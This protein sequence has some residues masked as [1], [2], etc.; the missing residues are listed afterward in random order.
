MAYGTLC[1]LEN[2]YPIEIKV[3]LA[4]LNNGQNSYYD[5]NKTIFPSVLENTPLR[6]AIIKRNRYMADNCNHVICYVNNSLS[7][8]YTFVKRAKRKGA[9]V[10]NLGTYGFD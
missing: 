9:N 2:K 5:F 1:K 4:Y 10:I 6:Y 8:A 7:N 3:V